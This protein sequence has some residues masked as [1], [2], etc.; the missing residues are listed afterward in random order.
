MKR[1]SMEKQKST[2]VSKRQRRIERKFEKI[3]PEK[4]NANKDE[5]MKKKRCF[6][7][8]CAVYATKCNHY[9]CPRSN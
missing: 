4:V 8:S 1:K 7:R 3:G 2:H 6:D 5:M 9:G